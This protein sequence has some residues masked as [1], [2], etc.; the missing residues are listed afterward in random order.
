MKKKLD[1]IRK[2]KKKPTSRGALFRNTLL[3]A[4]LGIALGVFAKW[5]DELSPD[6]RVWWQL[7]IEKLDL[8]S[9]FSGLPV[10]LTITLAIAVSSRSPGRAAL[11]GFVFLLGM[12]VA[13]H[14]YTVL[15]AGFN[16]DRY[17]MIWY[18]LTALSPLLAAICWYGRGT[19]NVPIVIDTLILAVMAM[20]CF[21]V[22]WVYI[23]LNGAV[24]AVLFAI[25][26]A[27]LYQKPKQILISAL[28][29]EAL[30]VAVSPLLPFSL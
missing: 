15:F 12:C 11:N 30:A 10:W 26:A 28:G 3:L 4:L 20:T 21:S 6:D 29:G 22:G 14:A 13:Y 9:V 19:G 7:I 2:P 16:P 23:G 8:S 5:L 18:S 25:A 17:M 1:K 27:L 24:N